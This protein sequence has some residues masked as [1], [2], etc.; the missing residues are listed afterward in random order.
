MMYG[1]GDDRQP[2]KKTTELMEKYLIEYIANLCNRTLNR[3]MRGGKDNMQLADL[4]HYLRSDP[5]KYNRIPLTL[6]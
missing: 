5:K 6:T 2:N 3:S 4:L 1:F